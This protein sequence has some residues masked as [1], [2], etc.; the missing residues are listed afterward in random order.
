[1]FYVPKTG[2]LVGSG[3]YGR[4]KQSIVFILLAVVKMMSTGLLTYLQS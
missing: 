4:H 2:L 3:K 1:V